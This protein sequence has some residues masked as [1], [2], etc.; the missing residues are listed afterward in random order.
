MLDLS[1]GFSGFSVADVP[2]ARA[3]YADVLGLDA[4]E[5]DGLLWLHLSGGRDVLA[6]PKGEAH[7]PATYTVLN[8][9][10]PD[11]PAAV[12]VLRGR[13]VRFERYEGTPTQTDE[14]GVFR[15]GGPLIAWFT[16]PS[17]NVLSVIEED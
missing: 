16:D 15:G 2:A 11:V 7:V 10:V 12:A 14:D 3:F 4:E 13:G 5:R 17:G 9:P 6:Y 1:R 8:F